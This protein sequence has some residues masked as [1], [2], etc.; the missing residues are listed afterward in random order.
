[1]ESPHVAK[2]FLQSINFTGVL[3]KML[4]WSILENANAIIILCSPENTKAWL[5]KNAAFI[6]KQ[7]KAETVL[8]FLYPFITTAL[9]YEN[10]IKASS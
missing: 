4:A 10:L 5:H 9:E 1:M 2:Q 8:Q 7:E 3:Q 6:S